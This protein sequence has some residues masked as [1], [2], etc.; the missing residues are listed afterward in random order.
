[1]GENAG[2]DADR[3]ETEAERIDR[4]LDEL[5]QELRVTSIGVQVLFAFLL[6]LPFTDRFTMLEDWQ[7][8][9]YTVDLVLAAVA[10]CLLITPVAHHR[11]TFR[12]HR[13]ATL[14]RQANRLAILGLVTV[15]AA[16]SGAVL[17]V[18]STFDTNP[19]AGAIAAGVAGL[20]VVLWF[21]VPLLDRDRDSY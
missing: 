14:L 13:K 18:V 7:R 5:L 21:V 4:N 17:L 9:L 6:G 8:T 3:H 2:G 16:I 10:T 11:L 1:V 15:A 19:V 20:F 12:Q